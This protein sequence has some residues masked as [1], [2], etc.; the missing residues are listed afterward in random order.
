M[1]TAGERSFIDKLLLVGVSQNLLERWEQS[2]ERVE[3]VEV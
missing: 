2:R 1:F 3:V